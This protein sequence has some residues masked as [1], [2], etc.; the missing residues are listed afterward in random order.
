MKTE[1][2]KGLGLEQAAIDA[3]MAEHGKDITAEK[4]KAKGFEDSLKAVEIKLKAFEGVDLEQLKGQIKT[5][6]DSLTAEKTAYEEK[7]ADIEFT[8][9]LETVVTGAKAR[10]TKAVIAMLD[11]NALKASK[12]QQADIAAAVEAVKK[13]DQYLFEPVAKF[14]GP[15]AGP[16]AHPAG[17][18]D[19]QAANEALRSIYSKGG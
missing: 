6:T 7:L 16:N 15:T 5:L 9:T 4:T 11:T 17:Q 1:F 12:N 3:I 8:R 18:S 10:N 14:N 2:L 19:T 13:S